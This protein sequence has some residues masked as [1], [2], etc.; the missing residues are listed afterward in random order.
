MIHRVEREHEETQRAE[1]PSFATS[2]GSTRFVGSE[3]FTSQTKTFNIGPSFFL[4]RFA[5]LDSRIQN[6]RC[7]IRPGFLMGVFPFGFPLKP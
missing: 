7:A 6:T 3:I 4:T 5:E 2:P 1:T